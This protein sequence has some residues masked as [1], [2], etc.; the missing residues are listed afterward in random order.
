MKI[1][2][3]SR[4][5]IQAEMEAANRGLWLKLVSEVQ[6]HGDE[7]YFWFLID[8]ERKLLEVY[9]AASAILSK[10]FGK[11]DDTQFNISFHQKSGGYSIMWDSISDEELRSGVLRQSLGSDP[12]SRPLRDRD[13]FGPNT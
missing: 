8:D 12:I 2:E 7:V 1:D 11:Y 10:Y 4:E 5:A 6:Y 9:E 3:R 13:V